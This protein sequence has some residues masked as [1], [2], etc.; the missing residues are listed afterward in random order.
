MF[1]QEL[2]LRREPVTKCIIKRIAVFYRKVFFMS[3]LKRQ[4]KCSIVVWVYIYIGT[5]ILH[6]SWIYHVILHNDFT[7]TLFHITCYSLWRTV[8]F[9]FRSWEMFA[10]M[11]MIMS[12]A[13]ACGMLLAVSA[14]VVCGLLMAV[15][16]EPVPR[17]RW[18]AGTVQWVWN[19]L[20]C[21]LRN[22]LML[23]MIDF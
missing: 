7:L 10:E 13:V 22:V 18:E 2:R 14:A 23:M 4:K 5:S 17:R 19:S 8:N 16:G 1:Q 20:L 11:L 21:W 9:I 15:S 12:A 3:K 6:P